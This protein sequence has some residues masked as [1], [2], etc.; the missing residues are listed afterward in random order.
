MGKVQE[1]VNS[2]NQF[3]ENLI[4][5]Q[6][7]AQTPR[8]K[9]IPNPSPE[10][11]LPIPHDEGESRQPVRATQFEQLLGDE[12]SP[13]QVSFRRLRSKIHGT[14]PRSLSRE[15]QGVRGSQRD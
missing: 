15:Y 8:D 6:N 2:L 3:V 1:S 13:T 12:P 14:R 5:H 11:A 10:E 4:G 9:D 7:P